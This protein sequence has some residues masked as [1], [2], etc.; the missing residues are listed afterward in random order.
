MNVKLPELITSQHEHD[1][2][3]DCDTLCLCL[4]L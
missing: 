4:P 3:E 1:Q 2:W